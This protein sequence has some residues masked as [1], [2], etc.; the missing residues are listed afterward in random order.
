MGFRNTATQNK[1]SYMDVKFSKTAFD[2]NVL[3]L[4]EKQLYNL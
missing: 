1:T 4:L 3:I 2:D